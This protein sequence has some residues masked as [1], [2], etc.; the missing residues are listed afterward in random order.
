ML[1][2]V[3]VLDVRV[4]HEHYQVENGL[5][6]LCRYWTCESEAIKYLVVA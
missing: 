4:R 2:H 5:G 3:T 6:A 1:M